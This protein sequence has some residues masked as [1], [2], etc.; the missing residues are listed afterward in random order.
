MFSFLKHFYIFSY[1]R[2]W[3]VVIKEFIQLRRDR[4]TFAMMIAIPIMQLIIFGYAINTNPKNLPTAVLELDHSEF[5]RAFI[6][7]LEN[8]D[9]FHVERVL[10]SESEGKKALEKWQDLFVITIPS[11]F[12]RRLLHGDRPQILIEADATDPVAT[13]SAL[14][15]IP[16][17]VQTVF[18]PLFVGNLGNL[19]IKSPSVDIVTHA[20]YNPE[21][22]TRYNIVPGLLGMVLMMTL[23][24]IASTCITREREKGTMEHLLSTPVRPL[25]VM[26]G[27]IT[28]FVIVGYIQAAL[29]L[30]A[31][32]F[33]FG[34]PILGSVILLLIVLFPFIAA[35]LAVGLTFSSL[36]KSQLQAGQMSTFF[37]LPSILLSGFMF[38]FKGMPLWAQ[39]IGNILPLTH[40]LR[41]VRGIVLKGNGFVLIW[42]DLW[43][44][45]L[46]MLIAMF[47]GLKRYSQTMD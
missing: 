14:S 2:F 30:F 38:P 3:A 28:P 27:K 25:E 44:I 9:Y 29:I 21:S 11:D 35:N 19:K 37:F 24:L 32:R 42:S 18:N 47:V 41:I 1:R 12:T 13:G 20:N 5:T 16:N 40:F 15:A 22:L 17:I 4:V 36:S 23:V 8:S 10:K 31:T 34:V 39:Y 6:Y 33:V 46:F 45:I 43:P 26:L 7:G